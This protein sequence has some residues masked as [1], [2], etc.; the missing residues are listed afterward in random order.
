VEQ[1]LSHRGKPFPVRQVPRPILLTPA[2]AGWQ[3][4]KKDKIA[5][6]IQGAYGRV[7]LWA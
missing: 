5:A 7:R 6:A 1:N 3:K 4:I 2:E